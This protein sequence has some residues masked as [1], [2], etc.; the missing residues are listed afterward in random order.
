MVTYQLQIT[1]SLVNEY[2]TKRPSEVIA[3]FSEPFPGS[4]ASND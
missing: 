4:A 3:Y 2:Q 1:N